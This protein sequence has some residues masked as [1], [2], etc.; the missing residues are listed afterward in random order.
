MG[1]RYYTLLVREKASEPWGIHFGDY[2]RECVEAERED[3]TAYPAV[4]GYHKRDTR[5]IRTGDTQAEIDAGVRA[6]NEER[7]NYNPVAV[8]K[9]IESSNR[10]GRKIS[11]AEA[12]AIHALLKG[13]H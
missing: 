2:D 1:R 11:G 4:S 8:N 5:I 9:A 13:R 12:K 3:I 10:A 6:L 7:G